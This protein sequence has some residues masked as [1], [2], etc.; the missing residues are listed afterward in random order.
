MDE[1]YFCRPFKPWFQ[2][3]SSYHG[4]KTNVYIANIGDFANDPELKCFCDTPDT[5]PPKGIMDLF[6]CIKAPMYASM[7]HFLDS[8]PEILK[9]VKGLNPDVNQHGIQI[10]FEPVSSTITVIVFFRY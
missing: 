4:I 8:D 9:N 3:K 10:D 7:P 2:K 6:K 5:C 1:F